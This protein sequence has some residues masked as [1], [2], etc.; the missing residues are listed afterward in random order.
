M[1][2]LVVDNDR[3]S[4]PCWVVDLESYRRWFHSDEFPEAARICFFSG[5][6]WVDMSKEQFFTHNQVKNAYNFVLT[7]LADTPPRGRWVPDGM[8]LV[9]EEVGL[10]CQ[11]D[12]TFFFLESLRSGKVRLGE[13]LEG[14]VELI[15][16]PDMVLEIMSAGSVQKD[17]ETLYDLYW[18][19]GVRE[20][21]LVDARGERPV[22][23][24]FRHGPRGFITTRKQGGWVKSAVFGKSFRL[25]REK[26]ELGNPE[27][28][29]QVR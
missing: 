9:N 8:L 22:F 12:G 28:R 21:W 19:A 14:I 20:Y 18:R 2:T 11:P 13:G 24:I 27:F 10:A 7:G 25:V 29:L 6:V 16:S 5:E 4:I 17:S 3:V 1:P 15:G 23:D 26:D